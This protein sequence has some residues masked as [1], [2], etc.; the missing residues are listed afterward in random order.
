MILGLCTELAILENVKF[1]STIGGTEEMGVILFAENKKSLKKIR[2]GDNADV[3]EWC[4][5]FP[6]TRAWDNFLRQIS[7]TTLIFS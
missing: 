7:K 6:V 5:Y 1:A 3:F 2:L 4:K